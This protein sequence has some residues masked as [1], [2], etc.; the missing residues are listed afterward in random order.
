MPLNIIFPIT[1]GLVVATLADGFAT[2]PTPFPGVTTQRL[3]PAAKTRRMVTVRNDSGPEEATQS[4]R[5]YGVNVWADSSVDAE[6]IALTGMAAVRKMP[7]GQPVTLV[8]QLTGPFEIED[9]PPYVVGGLNLTH[10]YFTFRLSC[11][12]IPFR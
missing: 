11:V 6:N 2:A 9:D 12:G 7:N 3:L 1:D 10:F 4:R 8:D 5:R